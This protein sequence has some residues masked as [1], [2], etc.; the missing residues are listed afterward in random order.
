MKSPRVPADRRAAQQCR[1]VGRLRH[2]GN[3]QLGLYIPVYHART[4]RAREETQQI[5]HSRPQP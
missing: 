3:C 5:R 1:G 4:R 2:A